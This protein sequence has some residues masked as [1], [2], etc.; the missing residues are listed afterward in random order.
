M[1]VNWQLKQSGGLVIPRLEFSIDDLGRLQ[2]LGVFAG[3]LKEAIGGYPDMIEKTFARSIDPGQDL[4]SALPAAFSEEGLFILIPDKLI[5]DEPVRVKLFNTSERALLYN[6]LIW[7]GKGSKAQIILEAAAPA[8]PQTASLMVG[9]LGIQ[10]GQN[11]SLQ[12]VESQLTPNRNWVIAHDKALLDT[13]SQLDWICLATEGQFTKHFL[14]VDLA[15]QG[16]SARMAGLYLTS[17]TQ[18]VEF[19]TRQNHLAPDTKSDLLFKGVLLDDSR[20]LF[21]GMIHVSPAAVKTD[22]YQ[23]NRNLI[24]GSGAHADTL[25]GLEILA[26][27][28]RCTHGA[29]VG[30]IDPTELF[31]LKSRGLDERE[32]QRVIIQGFLDQI[33]Q[34][35][36]VEKDREKMKKIIESKL[37]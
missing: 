7:L 13:G 27:D 4:F 11:S 14:Q 19:N 34:M 32:A 6:N 36:P 24:I 3:T 15:G 22:G 31:Y 17:G 8:E 29:T 21:S 1:P 23:A 33:V 16:T 37:N 18:Q 12:L 26:D 28:V 35:L 30:N 20:S 2:S 10:L 25:P 5:L 9:N